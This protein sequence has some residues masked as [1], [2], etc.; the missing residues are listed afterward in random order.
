MC[1]EGSAVGV[2]AE[3]AAQVAADGPGVL[4]EPRRPA[5]AEAGAPD[6]G[7]A[8]TGPSAT[9][10]GAQSDSLQGRG[11]VSPTLPRQGSHLAGGA[12]TTPPEWM[13]PHAN[14]HTAL[15]SLI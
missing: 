5:G 12:L 6:P 1:C 4:G 13:S 3:H 9:H 7:A 15:G 14:G 10:P 11:P 2:S 8:R